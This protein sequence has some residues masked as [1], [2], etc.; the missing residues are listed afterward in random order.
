MYLFPIPCDKQAS[1]NDEIFFLCSA[2]ELMNNRSYH[3]GW[4]KSS[5]K[6]NDKQ[7]CTVQLTWQKYINT[8]PTL[9]EVSSKG[10]C[11]SIPNSSYDTQNW[12]NMAWHGDH[13][14]TLCIKKWKLL[15]PHPCVFVCQSTHVPFHWFKRYA[16]LKLGVLASCQLKNELI[17][18]F[19]GKSIW[20]YFLINSCL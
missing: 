19:N 2:K 9:F 11:I 3:K 1:R 15:Y 10:T 8:Y 20:H 7:L 6:S 12:I 14:P 4:S 18:N 5:V 13:P 16:Y 17:Y